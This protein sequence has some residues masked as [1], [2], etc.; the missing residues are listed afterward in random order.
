M[1]TQLQQFKARI[2]DVDIRMSQFQ[3]S[4][5]FWAKDFTE[6]VRVEVQFEDD[7]TVYLTPAEYTALSR[8]EQ[9][10]IQHAPSSPAI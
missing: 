8:D 4:D 5:G 10:L 2:A 1:S 3:R 7:T 6:C 9:L